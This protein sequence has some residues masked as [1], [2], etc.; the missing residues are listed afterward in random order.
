M[1]RGRAYGTRDKLINRRKKGAD[2]MKLTLGDRP[3]RRFHYGPYTEVHRRRESG[4]DSAH[5]PETHQG[6]P[7]DDYELKGKA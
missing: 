1:P 7:Q 5:P 2:A 4:I 6:P 3:V